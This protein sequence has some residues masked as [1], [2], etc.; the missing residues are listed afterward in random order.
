MVIG[1]GWCLWVGSGCNRSI[2]RSMHAF[3]F[4]PLYS[5]VWTEREVALQIH[6]LCFQCSNE[7]IAVMTLG[8]WIGKDNMICCNW[9]IYSDLS[10]G[11]SNCWWFSI[12]MQS[13]HALS[14]IPGWLPWSISHQLWRRR[15]FHNHFKKIL[16]ESDKTIRFLFGN[17]PPSS[18]HHNY[19][20]F[21]VLGCETSICYY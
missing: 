17:F 4:E 18:N 5:G 1:C 19:H 3:L 2:W 13:I 20:K 6:L 11:H 21:F 9:P 10:W 12:P 8:I 7:E 16:D 15:E 14:L